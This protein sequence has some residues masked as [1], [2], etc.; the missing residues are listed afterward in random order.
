MKTSRLLGMF[1]ACV[2]AFV[3][4]SANAAENVVQNTSKYGAEDI[5]AHSVVTGVS[6]TNR[7]RND[8][9]SSEFLDT[10][11]IIS[12]GVL[13]V[14]LLRK[15][16]LSEALKVRQKGSRRF[17]LPV[18]FPLTDSRGVILIQDRRRLPDRRKVKNDFDDQK[19]MP[20]KKAS[21]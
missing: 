11:F 18:E 1:Y 10:V 19:S 8:T 21:N 2:I 14:W 6:L 12:C 15:T 17:D 16:N 4:A 20:M 9:L 3:S 5:S 13:G 7:N